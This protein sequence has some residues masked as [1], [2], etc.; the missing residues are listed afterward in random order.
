MI[1][2]L[3]KTADGYRTFLRV[4]SLPQYSFTGRQAWFPDEYAGM[5]GMPAPRV[6]KKRYAPPSWMWDYQ[7][8]ITSLSIRKGKFC[9]FADC[10]L[11][12][13]PILLEFARHA[14][15]VTSKPV[16]IVSPLMVIPQTIG[17]AK[18]FF[19]DGYRIQQVPAKDLE[20]FMALGCGIGITNYE[21]I[22]PDLSTMNIGTLIL[23]ESSLLKSHYG[24]WG[25][26][27]IELGRG[28]PFKL[29]CTGT[30]APNDRIEYANH[31]VFM[32]AFPTVNAFLA[33]YFVN[34]GETGER[35][36]LKPHALRPFYLALSAW[37]IFLTNPATY[38]WKDNAGE[39]PEIVTHIHDVALSRKQIELAAQDQDSLFPGCF[40][41]G[42]V[43]RSRMAQIA[44]GHYKGE[45][46]ESHKPDFIASLVDSFKGQSS[47]VWCKYNA[48]QEELATILPKAGNIDG[49][50][51]HEERVQIIAD[52]QAGKVKT[53]ISKPRILGFGLNLQRCTRMVFSGLH[54]SYEEYYQAVK[55]ANRYG[56]T[57]P[58]HVH[59]PV[60]DLERPMVENVL[61]KA[62]MV[63]KDTTE[64]ERIFK[65][66][67][68][69]AF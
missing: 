2:H 67:G 8:D 61:R 19:G 21:A 65:E 42:I 44:K 6:G 31:A 5:V 1:T 39:L 43:G 3:P 56:S 25:T 45:A 63:R 9:I 33:K 38:G 58:L 53:L 47:I 57:K 68:H 26:K 54:D 51:P 16:L 46:I 62:E 66:C 18:R 27:L 22:R 55:R 40:T 41:A 64:Q 50:T 10:G 49:Q 36:E 48:E 23:D 15:K 20:L 7:R 13:T 60:T 14:A 32:D 34:R 52:F 12:K 11:G 24:K 28:L 59:I 69:V 37:S 35:W 4:K 30:P 17:E 29:A